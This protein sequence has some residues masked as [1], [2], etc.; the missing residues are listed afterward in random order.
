[1]FLHL[2][3]HGNETN[4]RLSNNLYKQKKSMNGR[5]SKDKIEAALPLFL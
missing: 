1:M 2:T 4:E 5:G 3:I